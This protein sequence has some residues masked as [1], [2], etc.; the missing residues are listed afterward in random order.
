MEYTVGHTFSTRL[1]NY[2]KVLIVLSLV[3]NFGFI[4]ETHAKVAT[5]HDGIIV[6]T[7][8]GEAVHRLREVT[9]DTGPVSGIPSSV[10]KDIIEFLGLP[11]AEP[12]IGSRRFAPPFPRKPWNHI[13]QAKEFGSTCHDAGDVHFGHSGL[14]L[15]EDC[16]YLNVFV[17]PN[18][19]TADAKPV[20]VF[21]H[22]GGFI[23]GASNFPIVS[24]KPYKFLVECDCVYVNFNYRLGPLGFIALEEMK[25]EHGY[26]GV[27]GL[28]DQQ[29]A[30]KWVRDNIRSFGGNPEQITLMGESAGA[31]SICFHLASPES[32]GLFHRVIIQSAMCDMKFQDYNGIFSLIIFEECM[33]LISSLI[34]IFTSEAVQQGNRLVKVVECDHST[35]RLKCL[36]ELPV[37]NIQRAF[38]NKRGLLLHTGVRWFP[39]IDGTLV[40]DYPVHVMRQ[41]KH[42]KVDVII[43]NNADEA[44]LF[45]LIAYNIAVFESAW[46][47]LLPATFPTVHQRRVAA[48]FPENWTPFQKMAALLDNMFSCSTLRTAMALS[49]VPES[50]VF[51]YHY[52]FIPESLEWPFNDLGAFHGSELRYIFEANPAITEAENELSETIQGLW[53][54]FIQGNTATL[55]FKDVLW[56]RLGGEKKLYLDLHNGDLSARSAKEIQRL[57]ETEHHEHGSGPLFVNDTEP[58]PYAF[59][60]FFDSLL[61]SEKNLMVPPQDFE[62]AWDSYFVNVVVVSFLKKYTKHT[63]GVLVALFI[64]YMTRRWFIRRQTR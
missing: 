15:S 3:S 11:Y 17:P 12:P 60:P 36:R 31:F 58:T 28:M 29:L 27:L 2:G 46:R 40:P 26:A 33:E 1:S 10:D 7:K 52:T 59:C 47:D 50:H 22:G 5:I 35:D 43:G 56:P 18:T 6:H 30:L 51:L 61:V 25:E 16:L 9:H 39:V 34:V 24:P 49:S 38:K 32:A 41:S 23:M 48:L 8:S 13:F 37:E 4:C 64:V 55:R 14:P 42:N 21:I 57:I 63:A 54:H 62:E 19:T 53:Y 44:S 45:L 20:V